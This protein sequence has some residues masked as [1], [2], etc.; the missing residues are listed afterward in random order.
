MKLFPIGKHTIKVASMQRF[1][2]VPFD[3]LSRD[4]AENFIELELNDEGYKVSDVAHISRNMELAPGIKIFL[5]AKVW[6]SN[7]W[8]I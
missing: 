6:W 8:K 2:W 5:G 4:L 1:V 7:T 3:I